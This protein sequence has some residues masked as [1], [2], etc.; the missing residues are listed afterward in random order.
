MKGGDKKYLTELEL[1]QRIMSGLE[2]GVPVRNMTFTDE[3][4]ALVDD[5][6]LLTSKKV[7]YCANISEGQD[8]PGTETYR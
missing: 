2:Q 5:M 4:K 3:E 6:F 7:I 8:L 1:Q